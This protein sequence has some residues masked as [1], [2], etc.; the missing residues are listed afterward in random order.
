MLDVGCFSGRLIRTHQVQQGT[1]DGECEEII[2][3]IEDY[4]FAHLSPDFRFISRADVQEQRIEHF[5]G[6]VAS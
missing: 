4:E 3:D 2:D 6:I 5:S 1:A